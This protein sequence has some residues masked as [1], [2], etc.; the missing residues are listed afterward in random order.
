MAN[1]CDKIKNSANALL[2][3]AKMAELC[4]K[5]GFMGWVVT[6]AKVGWNVDDAVTSLTSLMFA[7]R[8]VLRCSSMGEEILMDSQESPKGVDLKA[9]S[10]AKRRGGCCR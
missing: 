1:K 5:A 8:N 4:A 6:S 9:A 7:R 10:K 2:T 3:G